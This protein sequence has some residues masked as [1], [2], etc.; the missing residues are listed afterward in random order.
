MSNPANITSNIN[1]IPMLNG[2]NF[3]D[4]KEN[5]LIILGV[6]DLDLALRVDYP[7]PVTNLSTS[8][9]KSEFERWERSNCMCMMIIKRAIPEAFRGAMSD[10]ITK[11]KL[12]LQISKKV[13]SKMKKLKLVQF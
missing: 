3:K 1:S 10:D 12:S 4:R 6:M 11:L 9:Q 13:L 5:L 7:A 2:S 8:D